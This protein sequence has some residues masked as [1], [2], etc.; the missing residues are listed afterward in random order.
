MAVDLKLIGFVLIVLLEAVACVVS[1]TSI[2]VGYLL[3][4]DSDGAH[5]CANK[6][7]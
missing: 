5:I 7:L 1:I 4:V 6:T 2:G 3:E